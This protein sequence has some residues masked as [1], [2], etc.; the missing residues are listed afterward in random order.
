MAVLERKDLGPQIGQ[1]GAHIG[2]G[3]SGIVPPAVVVLRL[4]HKQ[5]TREI[6]RTCAQGRRKQQ[7]LVLQTALLPDDYDV[8]CAVFGFGLGHLGPA[9][10]FWPKYMANGA[11]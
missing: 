10:V 3:D 1:G 11:K 4:G 9:P 6:R 7:G 5:A 2:I 8:E